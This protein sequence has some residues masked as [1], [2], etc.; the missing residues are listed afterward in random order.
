MKLKGQGESLIKIL[1]IA[2]IAVIAIALAKSY[3]QQTSRKT[4]ESVEEVFSS[5]LQSTSSLTAPV[6]LMQAPVACVPFPSGLTTP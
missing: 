6:L 2:I 3:F 1:V 4:Q 5:G